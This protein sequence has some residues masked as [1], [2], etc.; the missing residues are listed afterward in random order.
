MIGLI[1]QEHEGRD[2][3]GLGPRRLGLDTLAMCQCKRE[4]AVSRN[5]RVVPVHPNLPQPRSSVR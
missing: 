4:D 1:Q 2:A 3:S 5:V